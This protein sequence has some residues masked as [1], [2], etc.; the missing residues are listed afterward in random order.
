MVERKKKTF[1]RKAVL[2]IATCPINSRAADP[3]HKAKQ[4]AIFFSS[5]KPPRRV[6]RFQHIPIQILVEMTRI[7]LSLPPR[8]RQQSIGVA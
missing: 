8:A 5:T 3:G 1:H 7:F 4:R 6:F 2:Q